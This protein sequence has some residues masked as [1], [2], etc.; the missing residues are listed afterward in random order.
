MSAALAPPV[1]FGVEPALSGGHAVA[2][3]P[4]QLDLPLPS[5]TQIYSARPEAPVRYV[6]TEPLPAPIVRALLVPE[7]GWLAGGGALPAGELELDLCELPPH[8]ARRSEAPT[9][10]G[11]RNLF[12]ESI[13]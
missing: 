12:N 10:V 13:A 2:Q 5:A 9:T 8:A 1:T 11:M 4:E 6:P 3:A 7:A